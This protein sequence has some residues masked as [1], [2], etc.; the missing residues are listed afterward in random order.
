ME[1]DFNGNITLASNWNFGAGVVDVAGATAAGLMTTSPATGKPSVIPGDEAAILADYTHMIYRV[2]GTAFGEPGVLSIRAK[3]NLNIN[4][5]ITDGFFTFGDQTDIG[6]LNAAAG[7]TAYTPVAD[8][9]CS[10]SCNVIAN[11]TGAVPRISSSLVSLPAGLMSP[12]RPPP[13]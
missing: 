11:F 2:G 6:Y 10:P 8:P 1:L 9:S 13:I 4:G 5:S 12:C 7:G 3:G